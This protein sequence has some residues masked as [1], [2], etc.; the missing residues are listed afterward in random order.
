MTG[1]TPIVVTVA[2]GHDVDEVAHRLRASGMVVEQV[3]ATIGIVTGTAPA[4]WAG[5]SGLDGVAAVE[6]GRRVGT[7]PPPP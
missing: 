3:L 1:R 2:D 5:R 4:G 7:R 6:T